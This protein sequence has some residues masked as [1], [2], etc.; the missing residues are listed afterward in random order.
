LERRVRSAKLAVAL[1]RRPGVST[2]PRERQ[3][4]GLILA[5][6]D[7]ERLRPLIRAVAGDERPKQFCTLLGRQTLL[8]RT[9]RRAALAIAPAQ[10]VVALTR[11]HARFYRS[12]L[13]GMPAHCALV[14]PENRGTAPAI[15][16]GVLRIAAWAPGSAVAV[17]PSDHYVDDDGAFMRHVRAAF[18]AVEA[19]PDL[20]VLLGI[21]PSSPETD[22]GW[23][24]PAGPAAGT[25]LLR[26]G[27]FHEK[28]PATLADALLARGGLWN[29]F[30]M[31][32][33]VSAW[34]STI[35]QA[36]PALTAAFAGVAAAIG[37]PLESFAVRTLYRQ[38]PS[39]SFA[40]DVLATRPSNLAV[41]PVAGVG[42][43]DWGR[44]ARVL[45][46]LAGLGI[47]PAWAERARAL[48]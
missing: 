24:E 4:W 43:S 36:A 48:A 19:R 45:S 46:T 5:G 27:R 15:L 44:P 22:Y 37:T 32:A 21:A 6:G 2:F 13:R 20:V 35:R 8:E 26:V 11:R 1:H 14:Q 40:A 23:I 28:P 41:L 17:L 30:V 25:T 9:R 38:L 29:S 16:Y 10:T 31:V 7:G 34:L 42:W 47:R 3:R 18:A 12:L 33:G 39:S